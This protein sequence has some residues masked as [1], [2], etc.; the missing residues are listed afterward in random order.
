MDNDTLW[1]I[2]QSDIPVVWPQLRELSDPMT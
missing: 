2:I 1:S